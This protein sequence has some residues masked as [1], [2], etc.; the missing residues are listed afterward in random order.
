VQDHL[1]GEQLVGVT[2]PAFTVAGSGMVL[3]LRMGGGSG[4]ANSHLL[5]Y[6]DGR[7]TLNSEAESKFIDKGW[8]GGD[9][10]VNAYPHG[11]VVRNG[12]WHFTWC[13]RDTPDET[14]CHDLCYA[15]S[16]DEGRTWLNNDGQVIGVTG[17]SFITA[18]SPGVAVVK[19]PPGS[20]YRNGGSMT[21]DPSGG[22]HV[23]MRGEKG[24]PVFFSRDPRTGQWT[25]GSCKV[26][27]S[28]VCGPG[29]EIFVA[30]E[31]GVYR[32]AAGGLGQLQ[33][34]AALD[35]RWFKDSSCVLDR[36]RLAHDGW[37]SLIGQQGK[38]VSVIDCW[39]G[40]PS[41]L[42]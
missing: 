35:S 42:K 28:L 16:D 39:V 18:D 13:W 36:Q 17:R 11:L 31:G 2:Y 12:R 1:G 37:I 21:V 22:V 10:T 15:Y 6:S 23:V 34:L 3:Y 41:T 27:G 4:S 32:A 25:R 33:R 38:T 19:I 5:K 40:N 26:L 24:S 30:E 9:R 20:R 29:G 14:T 8:S 7:W